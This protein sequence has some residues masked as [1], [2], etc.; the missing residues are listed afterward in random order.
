MNLIQSIIY[1]KSLFEN[2]FQQFLNPHAHMKKKIKRFNNNPYSKKR[3]Y[4]A[5]MC[6]SR[7]KSVSNKTHTSFIYV[8]TVVIMYSYLR[9]PTKTQH[10][11]IHLNIHNF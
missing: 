5:I 6:R 9:D 8:F 2:I 4:N 10:P 11:V 3:L 7:L 1:L